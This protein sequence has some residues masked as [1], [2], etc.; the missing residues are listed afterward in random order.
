[1]EVESCPMEVESEEHV[2]LHYNVY[3][4]LRNELFLF[5]CSKKK[6]FRQFSPEE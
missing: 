6:N 1:M 2:I 3:N 5:A 4:D